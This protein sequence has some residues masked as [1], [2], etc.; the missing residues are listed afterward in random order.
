M[1]TTMLTLTLLLTTQ[2]SFA[3]NKGNTPQHCP[4][5]SALEHR[6]LSRCDG[7]TSQILG[8]RSRLANVEERAA[9]QVQE[10][11]TR[12]ASLT[13]ADVGAQC[14]QA[15]T[16]NSAVSRYN[17]ILLPLRRLRADM[18]SQTP[19]WRAGIRE[20]LAGLESASHERRAAALAEW[21]RFFALS[22]E[23]RPELE[24]KISTMENNVASFTQRMDR[25]FSTAQCPGGGLAE[26]YQR[27]AALSGAKP[28]PAPQ[29][30]AGRSDRIGTQEDYREGPYQTPQG[31]N[32]QA[33]ERQRLDNE[34]LRSGGTP[35]ELAARRAL[36]ERVRQATLLMVNQN[37]V[38]PY[39][40][41]SAVITD[42]R[43]ADDTVQRS[44][45]TGVHVAAQR[46]HDW[47]NFEFDRQ[48]Y[49]FGNQLPVLNRAMD[50]MVAGVGANG[51]ILFNRDSVI[52]RT[53]DVL[54]APLAA[55]H[56]LELVPEGT[57]PEPGQ[58]LYVMGYSGSDGTSFTSYRCTY[59]GMGP[60]LMTLNRES[61]GQGFV[62]DCPGAERNVGGMSGGPVVD[63]Q[64]R[65]Y[66]VLSAAPTGQ[67][68]LADRR[69]IAAPVYQ[70]AAGGLGTG[71]QAQGPVNQCL[72]T[73]LLGDL[74]YTCPILPGIQYT[75]GF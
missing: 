22:D 48:N 57:R 1:K 56:A 14:A 52:D 21:N 72:R 43:G 35:E 39:F 53:H 12:A 10:I 4:E 55:P 51:S 11:S 31:M 36:E 40:N 17:E 58:T 67:S 49:Y 61:V 54:A 75:A 19:Q 7:L 60:G 8:V 2:L 64:G 28:A 50:D 30:D 47:N 24:A 27:Q 41:G 68:D 46:N 18:I 9:A 73:G 66:G 13:D 25:V 38:S 42:V 37:G 71:P 45:V 70:R 26:I 33:L 3:G 44:A 34:Y 74:P 29:L 32:A 15:Q 5:A 65:L 6:L 62:L 23:F 63:T 16:L 20:A 59:Q 69:L